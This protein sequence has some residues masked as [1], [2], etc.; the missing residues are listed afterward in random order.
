MRACALLLDAADKRALAQAGSH[1][2]AGSELRR[3]A[4]QSAV[5]ILHEGVAALQNLNF[6]AEDLARVEKILGE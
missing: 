4:D 1:D 6:S 5:G 3:G 2:V